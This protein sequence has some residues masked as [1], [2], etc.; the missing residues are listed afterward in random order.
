MATDSP[1]PQPVRI[2]R[3]PKLALNGTPH[4]W[5]MILS[6]VAASFVLVGGVAGLG[7]LYIDRTEANSNAV[8]KEREA[9]I[10]LHQV[11][12]QMILR[13]IVENNKTKLTDQEKQ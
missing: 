8:A 7:K 11:Q 1:F 13:S 6:L 5:Q 2:K 9:R 4:L 3:I 10:K 12:F